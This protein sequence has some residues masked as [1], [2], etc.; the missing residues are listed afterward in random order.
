MTIKCKLN[1]K[2]VKDIKKETSIITDI[3]ETVNR[4]VDWS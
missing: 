1:V 2:Y 4:L 3:N